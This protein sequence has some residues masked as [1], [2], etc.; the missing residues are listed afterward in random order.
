[1]HAADEIIDFTLVF[2]RY[3]VSLYNYVLKMINDRMTAEDIVQNVFLQFYDNMK[4]IRNKSSVNYWLFKSARNEV[5]M[6]YRKKKIHKDK[7]DVA[8]TD[9]LELDSDYD[10]NDIIEK[11]EIKT[12]IEAELR[13]LPPEQSEVFL[14]KEYGGLSYS[15]I[16]SVMGT[17]EKLVKSRLFK[18]RRK[19]IDKLSGIMRY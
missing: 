5:Y 4:L 11:K 12:L 13:E 16:A 7:F 15:E 17:D 8:D 1:M 9:D 14:L 18:T 2:N 10:L 3:K 19:L 6:Y